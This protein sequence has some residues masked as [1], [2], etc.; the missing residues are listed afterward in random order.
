MCLFGR[1]T[2]IRDTQRH[3]EREEKKKREEGEE[4]EERR[5]KA[6]GERE[7]AHRRMFHWFSLWMT[8]MVRV[9]L[10]LKPEAQKSRWVSCRCPRVQELGQL[11]AV[12]LG[13]L[14]GSWIESGA[15]RAWTGA[16][17]GCH[18][19]QLNLLCHNTVLKLVLEAHAC[20][21]RHTCGDS[22]S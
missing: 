6:R 17:R 8:A 9:Y 10:G 3:T 7:E 18:R 11:S 5:I 21:E 15:S 12:F 20:T 16:H 1:V 19:R 4:E 13:A 22:L 2:E 14:S